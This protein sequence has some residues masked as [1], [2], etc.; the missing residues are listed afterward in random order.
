[1]TTSKMVPK[2]SDFSNSRDR[3][4]DMAQSNIGGK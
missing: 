2:V 1:M 3:K 4:R